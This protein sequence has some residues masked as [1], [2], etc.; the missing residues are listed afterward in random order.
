MKIG[1]LADSKSESEGSILSSFIISLL[2]S[3][4]V[5]QNIDVICK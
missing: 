2:V 4:K 5:K 3:G 1:L